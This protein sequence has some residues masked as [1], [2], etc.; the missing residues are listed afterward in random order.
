MMWVTADDGQGNMRESALGSTSSWLTTALQDEAKEVFRCGTLASSAVHTAETRIGSELET[1]SSLDTICAER[2]GTSNDNNNNNTTKVSLWEKRSLPGV[3]IDTDVLRS[4]HGKAS[5]LNIRGGVSPPAPASRPET[6]CG[7]AV[8][9]GRN[10]SVRRGDGAAPGEQ[11]PPASPSKKDPGRA[12]S[13]EM[14]AA[15]GCLTCRPSQGCNR[16]HGLWSQ[17]SGSMGENCQGGHTLTATPRTPASAPSFGAH[18]INEL[19][20]TEMCRSWMET[21]H[22]PLWCK[23]PVRARAGGAAPF[24]S[25]SQV[26]D[27]SV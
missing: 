9:P 4:V 15:R 11:L 20:K 5:T 25:S 18:A 3:H 26:Q 22:L 23:M 16:T 17:A 1:V 7:R 14:I 27:Q 8:S 13:N 10:S 6:S 12:A 2:A 24:T 19:Y 21:G